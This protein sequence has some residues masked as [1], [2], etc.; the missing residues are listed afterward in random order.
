MPD[1]RG[2]GEVYLPSHTSLTTNL[3][4][5]LL[6]DPILHTRKLRLRRVKELSGLELSSIW[7]QSTADP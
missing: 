5:L 1:P 6:K 3:C 4:S 7:F 2:W